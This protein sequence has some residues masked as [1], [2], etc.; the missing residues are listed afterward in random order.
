M[1]PHNLR[2]LNAMGSAK[3]CAMSTTEIIQAYLDGIPNTAVWFSSSI[4]GMKQHQWTASECYDMSVE[5]LPKKGTLLNCSC[6]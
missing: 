2:V 3:F 4:T 1:P 6:I 5:L